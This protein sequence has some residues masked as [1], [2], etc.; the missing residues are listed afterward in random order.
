[1]RSPPECRTS[2]SDL[3]NP[4]CHYSC[5]ELRVLDLRHRYLGVDELEPSRDLVCQVLDTCPA[6]TDCEAG[7]RHIHLQSDSDRGLLDL[8]APIPRVLQLLFEELIQLGE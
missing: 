6:P 4:R 5:I 7:P 8:Q 1:L 2:G 3:S